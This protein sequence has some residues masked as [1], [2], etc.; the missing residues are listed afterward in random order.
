MK[1][2]QVF[3]GELLA[4]F[5]RLM[6]AFGDR[7]DVIVSNINS[8]EA[9]ATRIASLAL[10][11]GYEAS[12]SQVKAREIMGKNFFG[13]EEAQKHFGAILSKRQLA[14]MA[15]I[16]F[17]EATLQAH[18]DSHILVAVVPVSIVAIRTATAKVKL[19]P[20]HCMFYQQDWY[21]KNTVGNDVAVLEWRLVRKT[22]VPDSTSKTW[23]EQQEL[24]DPKFDET[25]EAN[26]MVYTIIG[27]FLS[28][29]ERLFEKVWVRTRTLAP[30]GFRVFVGRFDADGLH[31]RNSLGD[32]H[33]RDSLAV[34]S[35]R[36]LES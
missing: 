35:S 16:P 2:T 4:A 32:G 28:T 33:V 25:P 18:K 21:D 34:A 24:L 20:K 13:I 7:A 3:G 27:H 5:S 22:P 9:V 23:P 8:D 26:V 15:E 19:P 36:K 17:S 11:N 31:V 10:N 30:D 29:G 1:W 6:A 12:V 14:Y